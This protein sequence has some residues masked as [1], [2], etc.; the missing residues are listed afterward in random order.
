ERA[1][2]AD[3]RRNTCKGPIF[4]GADGGAEEGPSGLDRPTLGQIGSS[5]D[6]PRRR[7]V[8]KD[9]SGRIG[10]AWA[11]SARLP[12]YLVSPT[13]GSPEPT[14]RPPWESQAEALNDRRRLIAAEPNGPRAPT[15]GEIPAKALFL[16]APMGAPK[17][18]RAGSIGRPWDKSAP[19]TM[20]LVE[21]RCPRTV[22]VESAALGPNPLVFRHTL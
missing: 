7:A 4:G 13:S 5:Y 12:T 6:V 17:R 3:S 18:G 19:P 21:G 8:S 20:Y 14:R 16:G 11:K 9:R 2:S 10:C 1:P 22:R 15:A